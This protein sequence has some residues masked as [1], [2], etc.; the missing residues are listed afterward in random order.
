MERLNLVNLRHRQLQNFENLKLFSS[1]ILAA[2]VLPRLYRQMSDFLL[3]YNYYSYWKSFLLESHAIFYCHCLLDSQSFCGVK[4]VL[5]FII[6]WV[7]K[8]DTLFPRQYM[9]YIACAIDIL[10]IC[11][12]VCTLVH[13]HM[14]LSEQ[15]WPRFLVTSV[16]R[17]ICPRHRPS[18]YVY[19]CDLKTS[20]LFQNFS[21]DCRT[22]ICTSFDIT[23]CS[24]SERNPG[25]LWICKKRQT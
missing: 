1:I 13:V 17:Q 4:T 22:G 14:F 15:K 23:T 16:T 6:R 9:S 24:R 19:V 20:T 12:Y 8:L 7:L 10:C 3:Q 11:T 2:A 21:P 18:L 25:S 5:H